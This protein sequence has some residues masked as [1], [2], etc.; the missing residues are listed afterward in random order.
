MENTAKIIILGAAAVL[1]SGV[2][3]EDW[4][5]VQKY[6]PGALKRMD[7]DGEPRFRVMAWQGAGSVNE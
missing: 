1:V 2:K 3:L 7:E 6:A 4:K 5:L